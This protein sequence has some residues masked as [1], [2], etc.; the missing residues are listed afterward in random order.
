MKRCDKCGNRYCFDC[1][2]K[3]YKPMM[4]T[5]ELCLVY[6]RKQKDEYG[7]D[8]NRYYPVW[9]LLSS[10]IEEEFTPC[11]AAIKEVHKN[12]FRNLNLIAIPSCEKIGREDLHNQAYI[13]RKDMH[14]QAYFDIIKKAKEFVKSA[15]I[16]NYF[17][18]N[19]MK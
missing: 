9:F 1:H 2:I 19:K 15:H 8:F 18:A 6:H 14:N 5:K 11:V 16:E 13:G 7:E 17:L 10:N 4:L 3:V 12:N